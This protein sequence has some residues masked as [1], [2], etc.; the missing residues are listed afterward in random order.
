MS[1]SL[2]SHE[3]KVRKS[4]SRQASQTLLVVITWGENGRKPEFSLD[5]WD[6]DRKNKV[7]FCGTL[8]IKRR[9]YRAARSAEGDDASKPRRKK[10]VGL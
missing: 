3:N 1:V 7:N 8:S 5:C 6:R 10:M 2:F 9:G 4:E